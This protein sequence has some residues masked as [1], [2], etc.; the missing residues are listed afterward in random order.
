MGKEKDGLITSVPEAL[1]EAAK[2]NMAAAKEMASS[3]VATFV[4]TVTGR[5]KP[6]RGSRRASKKKASSAS[7]RRKAGSSAATK[8]VSTSKRGVS[9]R[10]A[11]KKP[12]RKFDQATRRTAT[13][14]RGSA[15]LVE[16]KETLARMAVEKHIRFEVKGEKDFILD[17]QG[18]STLWR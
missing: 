15:K 16:G 7:K 18:A 14:A 8:P 10:T 12:A 17:D 6:R 2:I 1:T 5:Q 4:D 13:K 11:A 9:R 3:A